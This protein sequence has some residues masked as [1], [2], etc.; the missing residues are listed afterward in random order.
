MNISKANIERVLAIFYLVIMLTQFI[1]IEGYDVSMPKACAMALTPLFLLFVW[2]DRNIFN[3]FFYATIYYI[4][5]IVCSLFSPII[6]WNRIL[7]RGLYLSMFILFSYLVLK[8]TFDTKLIIKLMGCIIITYTVFVIFQQIAQGIFGLRQV[9]LINLCGGMAQK[10]S[11]LP[12]ANGLAIEPSHVGRILTLCYFTFIRCWEIE[13]CR[14]SSFFIMCKEKPYVTYAYIYTM[15]FIGSTTAMI[16]LILILFYLFRHNTMLIIALILVMLLMLNLDFYPFNRMNVVINALFSDDVTGTMRKTESSGLVRI[17]PIINTLSEL[18][19]F[20]KEAWVGM[21]TA[22]S[23]NV[24]TMLH[25]TKTMIGDITNYG[26]TTYL[27]SMLFIYKCCINKI[28]SFESLLFLVLLGFGIGSLYYLW[29]GL[30]LFTI[31]KY[32]ENQ[33]EN[34][35][36]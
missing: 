5:L 35:V 31:I 4:I 18:D 7:F 27:A 36:I 17:L 25:S 11:L 8:G 22:T 24:Y 34:S 32:F 33:Q 23:R 9:P 16:G 21:G 19:L 13:Q 3:V 29:G 12:K 28:I 2:K 20:S 6:V 10:A 30:M 15:M 26:L 1:P 14:K